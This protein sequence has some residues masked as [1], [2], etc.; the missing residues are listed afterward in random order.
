MEGLQQE[1]R[2]LYGKTLPSAAKSKSPSQSKWPVSL[3]HCFARIILDNVVGVTTPWTNV[4]KKPAYKNMSEEQLQCSIALGTD[5]LEGRADL[6]ALD[7]KSLEL[8]NKTQ[9]KVVTEAGTID[10]AT[11][12][13]EESK[14]KSHDVKVKI[15]TEDEKSATR[16]VST[17]FTPQKRQRD[18]SQDDSKQSKKAARILPSSISLPPQSPVSAKTKSSIRDSRT[19]QEMYD[20]IESTKGMS[21]F[22][23]RVLQCL[24]EV[25]MGEFTTY[26]AISRHLASSPRAVGSALRNNPYAPDV[27]CHRVVSAAG[28]I[29]GFG[30]EWD[31]RQDGT[32]TTLACEK[33][34]LLRREGVKFDGKMMLVGAPFSRFSEIDR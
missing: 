6:I 20:K 4:L 12:K 14:H 7:N 31:V 30:G 29:G 8:R 32:S 3:D 5:I 9:K 15:A 2:E 17:Y 26:A 25:P 21:P 19:H 16:A 1:W 28:K 11:T 24:L 10:D 13:V 34:G 33:V 23:K 18:D 22:R 27:P